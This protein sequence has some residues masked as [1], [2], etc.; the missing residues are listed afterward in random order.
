MSNSEYYPPEFRPLMSEPNEPEKSTE[1]GLDRSKD[2]DIPVIDME[3]LDMEKLREA[4]KD[5]GIFHLE[6]TGIPLTLMSQVKEITES[7][8]SLPFEEKRT[9]FGVNSPLSYYWGTHTVSPSGKAVTRAPQE[10]S[11]HL[12]EG[13]N[14]PLAS[15]SRLLA[16]SCTDPK[17]ESF[18]MVMKEY[19]KHVTR[20]IVTLFEAIILTLSL[21]LSGDQKMSYLSESTSVIRVQRYPQCT[22]SPGLEA[23]TDSSVISIIN[24]DD[25]GG[26]EFLKD[27]HWFNVISD[28][29]Y[30]SVLHKVGKRMRKKERYSIVYF[31]FPDKDCMFN[32]SRYKPFKFLEFEAQVKLDVETHGSKVGLSRFLSNP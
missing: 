22:G 24:Q 15:L 26:L 1:S 29:E 4:C 13:I 12:F 30:K 32:S 10:S 16:L 3:H 11:G 8:L 27:G 18:R 20:I 17:L 5:W 6:N 28:E 25:V 31:V 14:I 2:I 19:G 21:E 23:H 9:L 7:V